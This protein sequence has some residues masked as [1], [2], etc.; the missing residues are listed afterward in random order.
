MPGESDLHPVSPK[1]TALQYQPVE[2]NKIKG[3]TAED[4]R[5]LAAKANKIALAHQSHT[6]E[7][8]VCKVILQRH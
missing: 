8:R 6:I 5:Y 1:T 3:K 2:R 4:K 7:Y